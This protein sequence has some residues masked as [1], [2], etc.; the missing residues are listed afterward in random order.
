MYINEHNYYSFKSFDCFGFVSISKVTDKIQQLNY[1]TKYITKE[2]FELGK[3][4]HT[5]F[6]SNNLINGNVLYDLVIRNGD[7]IGF[8]FSNDYCSLKELSFEESNNFIEEIFD[9]YFYCYYND[10]DTY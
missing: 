7:K 10:I 9:K 4:K 2:L 6:R 5:Y 8:D 1:M 3:G